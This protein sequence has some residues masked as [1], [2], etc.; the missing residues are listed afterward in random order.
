MVRRFGFCRRFGTSRVAGRMNVYGPGVLADQGE[1]VF[2]VGAP[3]AMDSIHRPL[4]ADMTPEGIARIRG[5]RDQATFAND[6]DNL[7]DAPGLRVLRMDFDEFGHARIL[8]K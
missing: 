5:I 7:A 8:V 3:D 1:I 2:P 4:V 6:F